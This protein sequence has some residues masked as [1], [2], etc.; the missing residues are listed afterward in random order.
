MGIRNDTTLPCY[1][2]RVL[3]ACGALIVQSYGRA[4]KRSGI[5]QDKFLYPPT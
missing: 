1:Q 5:L 3:S 4:E 2:Y